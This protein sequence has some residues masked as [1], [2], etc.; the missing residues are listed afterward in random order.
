M[1]RGRGRPR[2]RT[3]SGTRLGRSN[4]EDNFTNN[5]TID[6]FSLEENNQTSKTRNNSLNN[7]S[8]SALEDEKPR[9]NR[10]SEPRKRGRKRKAMIPQEDRYTPSADPAKRGNIILF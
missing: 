6:D 8:D 4:N 7:E 9:R 1:P 3:R 2:T 5:L 10:D